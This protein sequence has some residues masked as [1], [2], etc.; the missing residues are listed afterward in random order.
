MVLLNIAK[1]ILHIKGIMCNIIGVCFFILETTLEEV[2]RKRMNPNCQK[3]NHDRLS[4][5]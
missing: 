3:V 2:K 1:I 5:P 4:I